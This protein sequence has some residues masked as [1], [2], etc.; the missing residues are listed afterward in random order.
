MIIP[1]LDMNTNE[2]KDAVICLRREGQDVK[3]LDVTGLPDGKSIN[4]EKSNDGINWKT[5]PKNDGAPFIITT[6]ESFGLATGRWYIRLLLDVDV[7]PEGLIAT[8]V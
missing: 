6:N 8:L 4:V 2:K 7:L 5:Y 1:I 3:S